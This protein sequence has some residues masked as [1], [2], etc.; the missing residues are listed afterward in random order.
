MNTR[1]S[2]PEGPSR[3]E[4]VGVVAPTV[5]GGVVAAVVTVSMCGG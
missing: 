3:T 2:I 1:Y 5:S 4:H